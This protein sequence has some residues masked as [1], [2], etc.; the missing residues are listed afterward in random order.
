MGAPFTWS[1]L[2]QEMPLYVASQV[3]IALSSGHWPRQFLYQR[4]DEDVRSATGRGF[5]ESILLEGVDVAL[6]ST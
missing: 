1:H 6:R 4:T 2:R 3:G 5:D